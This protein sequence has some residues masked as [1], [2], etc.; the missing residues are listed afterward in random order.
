MQRNRRLINCRASFLPALFPAKSSLWNSLRTASS[1]RVHRAGLA[2]LTSDPASEVADASIV[3]STEVAIYRG[4]PACHRLPCLLPLRLDQTLF[5]LLFAQIA[6]SASRFTPTG[7][8]VL[9]CRV[10]GVTPRPG[11]GLGWA[12]KTKARRR[13]KQKREDAQNKGTKTHKTKARRRTKQRREATCVYLCIL[14]MHRLDIYVSVFLPSFLEFFPPL[15]LQMPS[16]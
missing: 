6:T 2:S 15:Y 12:R 9:S 1:P 7:T 8:I 11:R 5:C 16:M 10:P 13:A 14:H 3:P 4:W